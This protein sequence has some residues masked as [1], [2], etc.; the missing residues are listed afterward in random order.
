MADIE[1]NTTAFDALYFNEGAT[2]TTPQSGDWDIQFKSDGM[3]IEDDAGT[4][5]GPYGTSSVPVGAPMPP[6]MVALSDESTAITATGEKFSIRAPFAFTLTDVRANLVGATTT[7]TITVDVNEGGTTVLSTK[8]TIDAT[9][10]TS[11]TAATAAVI[12]DSAI[13]DD[14]ELTFDVDDVGDSTAT[15]LKVTLYGTYA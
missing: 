4:E 6:I 12:S 15:G 7:G 11:T 9:E 14:A 2:V 13:A 5:V 10:L 3:Y 8:L 1:A